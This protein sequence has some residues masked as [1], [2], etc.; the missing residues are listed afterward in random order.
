MTVAAG[1]ALALV[2]TIAL[3][4][5]WFIQH[6]AASGLPTLELR[7]PL[8]AL[9]V[10]FTNRRWLLGGAA[11]IAGWGL[12]IAALA[13]A[14]LSIVQGISAGGIGVLAVLAG[15]G[16]D[17]RRA[18]GLCLAGLVLVAASLAGGVPS[19]HDAS[20]LGLVLWLAVSAV[21]AGVLG[22]VVG[23]GAGLGLAA[24]TLYAAGDVGTKSVVDGRWLVAVAV[25]ACNICGFAA[26][27][28]AFQRGGALVTAGLN[29]LATNA[30][31]IV[32]GV[33]VF[34]EGIPAGAAGVAR[35]IG[36]AAVV[37]GAC[38]LARLEVAAEPVP[39]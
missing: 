34:A 31:P 10:L 32:A 12:Y 14:P 5:S 7:R 16:R 6:D 21:A 18:V 2:S 37:G 29:M 28:L 17:E 4:L 13:L 15:H 33:A 25:I 11:G 30:L 26:L 1:L 36:F 3:N 38:L 9:R 27:Q 22:G 35:G 23:G 24:G 8:T 39:T 20:L 19:G